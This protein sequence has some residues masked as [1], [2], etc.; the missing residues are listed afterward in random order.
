MKDDRT[1]LLHIRDAIERIRAYTDGGKPE[2]LAKPIIQDAV[3]RNLEVIGEAA[4]QV[5]DDLR[6]EYPDVPWSKMTG[7][8][9][10]LIHGYMTVDLEIVWDVV[11]NRLPKVAKSVSA[12]LQ[13]RA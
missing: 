10:V 4:K 9:D 11:S 3:I 5:S 2:F 7:L 8:R 1:Y 13:D 6:S 12:V